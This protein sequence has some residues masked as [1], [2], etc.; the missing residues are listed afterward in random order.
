MFLQ[1]LRGGKFSASGKLIHEKNQ[2]SKIPW[3]CPFKAFHFRHRLNME[4][5]LQS[6]LGSMSR[7]MC[8]AVLIGPATPRHPPYPP[9][10]GL[11]YEGA[12]CANGQQRLTTSLCN[13]WF[14]EIGITATASPRTSSL[15]G[16]V[17]VSADWSW[18]TGDIGLA[19]LC[20]YDSS[21]VLYTKPK[22]PLAL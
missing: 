20:I 8:T 19:V 7:V 12:N 21:N 6:Y 1:I 2:K 10:L 14:Q 3:H 9:A 15:S 16:S 18:E 13:P 4:V 22:S 5:D 17:C 11:V